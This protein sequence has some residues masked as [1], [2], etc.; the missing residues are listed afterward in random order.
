VAI[1]AASTALHPLVCYDFDRNITKGASGTAVRHLQLFLTQEGQTIPSSEYGTFG[2]NTMA[3]V[4]AFQEKNAADIL[5]PANLS[6]G[7]GF[8][9]KATRAKLNA[10]YGC[11]ALGTTTI[12]SW[13]GGPVAIAVKNVSLDSNG[14]TVTACNIGA[15]NL[16]TIPVRI[17]LNGIN[18]DFEFVGS[19]KSGS[20][21]TN[22]FG[23]PTWGINYDAGATYGAVTLLDPNNYYKKASLAY[24]TGT[25]TLAV[26]AIL[27][28]HLAA[29][30][31]LLKTTGVQ[32]TFCNLGTNDVSV[33]PARVIV[34]GAAKD[35][36]VSNAYK[37]GTCQTVNWGYENWNIVGAAGMTVSATVI[38]DPNNVVN[39]V[40]E[41]DNA[42][43]VVGTL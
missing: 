19:Q 30:S 10:K 5:T 18:R 37:A 21:S 43:T 35:F 41:F 32:I 1:P 33:F 15:N 14:V 22:T 4:K 23:Y 17:R 27:G 16:P 31:I 9:G 25:T 8:V 40:N 7:N 3:A 39:E 6:G 28:A 38:T 42:S 20:C 29:R 11:A 36:T 12:S 26:P 2:E 34:N 13:N 24:P